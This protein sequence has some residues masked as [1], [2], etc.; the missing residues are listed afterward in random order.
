MGDLDFSE[1]EDMDFDFSDLEG[2]DFGGFWS[3]GFYH[4]LIQDK[5]INTINA[6]KSIIISLYFLK[7]FNFLS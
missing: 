5:L 1:L 3:S 6:F 4:F 2:M 7:Y